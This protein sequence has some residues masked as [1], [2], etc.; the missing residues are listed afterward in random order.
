MRQRVLRGRE[1]RASGRAWGSLRDTRPLAEALL[2]PEPSP[3][4]TH[5][6]RSACARPRT[7]RWRR[8]VGVCRAGLPAQCGGPSRRGWLG[9][10]VGKLRPGASVSTWREGLPGARLTPYTA[11]STWGRGRCRARLPG[12]PLASG[13]PGPDERGCAL[14]GGHRSLRCCAS[15]SPD[16]AALGAHGG[17][18]PAWQGCGAGREE[19]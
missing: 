6:Y 18:C 10:G 11:H 15:W 14:L 17:R 2:R 12:R 19:S 4:P 7:Q 5:W 13:H 9:V 3:C 1:Q 16:I 8:G